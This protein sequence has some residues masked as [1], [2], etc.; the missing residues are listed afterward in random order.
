MGLFSK[1]ETMPAFDIFWEVY[2]LK[3]GKGAAR[4]A[5]VRAIRKISEEDVING[6]I[7]YR[8]EKREQNTP[9]RYIKHP[10]TW[11]NGECWDDEPDH[12][13]VSSGAG[14]AGAVNDPIAA[15]VCRVVA[16]RIGLRNRDEERE[17][18]VGVEN[19]LFSFTK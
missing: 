13:G 18:R 10:A 2:P 19:S 9:G 15:A 7:R 16:E 1:L 11:L 4:K 8:Q 17:E 12:R 5:W 3:K 14:P 6:A